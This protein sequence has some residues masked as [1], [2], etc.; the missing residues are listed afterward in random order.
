MRLP[1]RRPL[2][3]LGP[4]QRYK[5]TWQ[6]RI[7]MKIETTIIYLLI[8]SALLVSLAGVGFLVWWGLSLLW[9]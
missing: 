1:N 9:S 6:T 7:K 4:N 5:P 3:H 2:I 8:I